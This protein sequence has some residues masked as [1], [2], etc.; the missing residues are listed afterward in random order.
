MLEK[1]RVLKVSVYPKFDLFLKKDKQCFSLFQ[2]DLF[3]IFH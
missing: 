3:A 1:F 2:I